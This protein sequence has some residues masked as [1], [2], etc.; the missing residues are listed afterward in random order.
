MRAY[1]I[2]ITGLVLLV[3]Q[4]LTPVQAETRTWK[5]AA[6]GNWF[7]TNNWSPND[8]YPQVG[9][10]VIVTNTSILLTNETA[11]LASFSISNAT[12]TFT[13]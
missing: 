9:D 10:T 8:N 2:I 1:N 5:G 3:S 12:L 4:G 7:T 11:V 6:N 13:H